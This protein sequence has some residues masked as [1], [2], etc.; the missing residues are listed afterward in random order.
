MDGGGRQLGGRAGCAHPPGLTPGACMDGGHS[1]VGEGRLRPS[2]WSHAWCLHGRG[3]RQLGGRAGCAH[4]PGLTPGAWMDGGAASWGA[5]QAAPIPLAPG[6]PA[7]ARAAGQSVP[8]APPPARYLPG[9]RGGLCPG[10]LQS[11]GGG[12]GPGAC[13]WSACAGRQ[14]GA[15]RRAA[16]SAAAVGDVGSS[17]GG[18]GGGGESGRRR[19]QPSPAR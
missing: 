18:G 4:P 10:A 9:W 7:S 11:G 19:A 2:S 13:H 5:G 14:Q 1:S 16:V 8:E 12:G 17:P 15:L 3:G 6:R